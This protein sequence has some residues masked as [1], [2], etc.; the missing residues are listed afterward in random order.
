MVGAGLGFLWFNSYPAQ[1]FME[2]SVASGR[3]ARHYRSDHRMRSSWS[4]SA[5]S[6]LEALSVIFQVTSFRLYGKRILLHGPH[7]PP[8]RT[9]R[10][11]EPKIIVVLDHQHHSGLGVTVEVEV[12][13]TCGGFFRKKA[14]SSAPARPGWP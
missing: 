12:E 1:V 2:M 3:G 9:Q 11:A 6:S 5:A 7:P 10:V 14:S 13:I 4:S 8:F